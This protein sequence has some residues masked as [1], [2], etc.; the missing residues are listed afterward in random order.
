MPPLSYYLG[1]K[2]YLTERTFAVSVE[3]G[4][5]RVAH[6]ETCVSHGVFSSVYSSDR[7]IFTNTLVVNYWPPINDPVIAAEQFSK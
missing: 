7:T 1:I 4:I 3:W 5:S 6:T 2:F